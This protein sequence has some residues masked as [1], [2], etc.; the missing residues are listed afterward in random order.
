MTASRVVPLVVIA[1][2]LVVLAVVFL[3][4]FMRYRSFRDS[5]DDFL[6]L[7][8]D[9][10][11]IAAANYVMDA[12]YEKLVEIIDSSVPPDYHRDLAALNVSSVE[13]NDERYAVR[14]VARFQGS[15]YSGVGQAR[16]RWQRTPQGW[17]FALRD[18]QIAE[19]YPEGSFV[20][21]E[22]YLQNSDLF[23]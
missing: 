5:L 9:G 22:S 21:L 8:K 16:M 18:V 10:D 13:W 14:I 19:G 17:R 15:R 1:L 11:P 2:V 23:N 20:S 12:D 7:V 6:S 4:G 3:P